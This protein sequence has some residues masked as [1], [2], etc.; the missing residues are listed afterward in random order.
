[1]S[2]STGPKVRP[3]GWTQQQN[4]IRAL[5]ALVATS[6][7]RT[8]GVSIAEVAARRTI[9]AE[10]GAALGT[11]AGTAAH[12]IKQASAEQLTEMLRGLL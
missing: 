5:A 8:E 12:R 7:R 6:F 4:V 3:D 2:E 11:D 9:A 1:M 10:L